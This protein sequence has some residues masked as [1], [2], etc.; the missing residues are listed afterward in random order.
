VELAA[1]LE[2]AD[3]GIADEHDPAVAILE[4]R[5]LTNKLFGHERI[6]LP[7]RSERFRAVLAGVNAD[8]RYYVSL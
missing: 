7:S 6:Y 4:F 1:V 3:L 8:A 2:D 5:D